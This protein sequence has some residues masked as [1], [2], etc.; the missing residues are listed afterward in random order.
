ML[1]ADVFST[2]IRN[3]FPGIFE[4][5]Q[6][7]DYNEVVI[8]G[9]MIAVCLI[10]MATVLIIFIL[11]RLKMIGILKTLGMRNGPLRNIF[12]H[13]ISPHNI[14]GLLWGNIVGLGLAWIQYHFKVIKLNEGRLLFINSAYRISIQSYMLINICTLLIIMLFLVIPSSLVA[15]I[16]P[17]KSI[18]YN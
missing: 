9:L 17:V 18:S 4:W 10:N 5:L 16:S 1:P 7:Q 14:F 13:S 2:T 11:N 15:R 6:L 12:L 3:K 8:L